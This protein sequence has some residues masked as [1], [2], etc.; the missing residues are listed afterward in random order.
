M[1][2]STESIDA[3]QANEAASE[4]PLGRGAPVWKLLHRQLEKVSRKMAADS[5]QSDVA[6]RLATWDVVLSA[7]E[8]K[9][10][11]MPTSVA[12]PE[13]SILAPAVALRVQAYPAACATAVLD[14][15]Q[16]SPLAALEP[17]NFD[18]ALHCVLDG[19]GTIWT[20]VRSLLTN[21]Q[22]PVSTRK[23]AIMMCSSFYS[24]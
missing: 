9:M 20:A 1:Y 10:E 7:S 24:M 14:W 17:R 8:R 18:Y 3:P 12:T 4:D 16:T 13:K 19:S 2:L 5:T 6:A 23:S 21:Q 15:C 11:R 22:R